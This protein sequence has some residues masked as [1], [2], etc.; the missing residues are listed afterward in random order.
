MHIFYVP[1]DRSKCITI[2]LLLLGKLSIHT[3]GRHMF[4][5]VVRAFRHQMSLK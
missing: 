2:Y 5:T 3:K 4:V 1:V